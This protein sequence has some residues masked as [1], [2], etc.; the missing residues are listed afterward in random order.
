M[1]VYSLTSSQTGRTY[2]VT[3]DHGPGETPPENVFAEIGQQ[4]DEEAARAAGVDPQVL[5]QGPL[6]TIVNKVRDVGPGFVGGVMESGGALL[7]AAARGIGQLTGT[8]PGGLF[9]DISRAGEVIQQEG[10]NLRPTNPFNETAN[11]IGGG[12]QQA[13]GMV[14]T[15]GAAATLTGVKTAMTTVP[16][17]LGAVQGGGQGVQTAQ[18]MGITSPAGQLA[19]AVPFAGAEVLAERL[20]GVGSK[21]LSEAVQQ[22]M[23]GTFK[24]AAK[25]MGS[26]AIEEPLTG[27]LQD[28]TTAAAGQF[29]ADPQRPGYTTTG[30]ELPRLKQ[31]F[32]NRRVQEAIG[33]AAGGLVFAGLQ[34]ASPRNDNL[35]PNQT[36]GTPGLEEHTGELTAADVQDLEMGRQ[37]VQDSR[38]F[39]SRPNPAITGLA[40]Q[41]AAVAQGQQW[42]EMSPTLKQSLLTVR[43]GQ[44]D[45]QTVRQGDSER[46]RGVKAL[47]QTGGQRSDVAEVGTAGAVPSIATAYQS[48]TKGQSTAFIP[49]HD[50]WQQAK[51]ANPKLEPGDFVDE[52]M[53]QYQDG[54]VMLE[55]ANS[56]QEADAAGLTI[57][58]TPVGTAVRMAMPQRSFAKRT[59]G[60]HPSAEQIASTLQAAGYRNTALN[61]WEKPW[62]G[63]TL[64]LTDAKPANFIIA[65]GEIVPVDVIVEQVPQNS[66]SS[67][68]QAEPGTTAATAANLITEPELRRAVTLGTRIWDQV[69]GGL[70]KPVRFLPAQGHTD[71]GRFTPTDG[72]HDEIKLN[73]HAAGMDEDA[74]TVI[75]ELA[76]AQDSTGLQTMDSENPQPG[77]PMARLMAELNEN[78]PTAKKLNQAAAEWRALPNKTAEEQEVAE[79]LAYLA[80]PE[81]RFARAVEQVTRW[82]SQGRVLTGKGSYY[83]SGYLTVPEMQRILPLLHDILGHGTQSTRLS[84]AQNQPGG[85]QARSAARDRSSRP[86]PASGGSARN[87]GGRN[88]GLSGQPA[89]ALG[90]NETQSRFASPNAAKREISTRT[91]EQ[92]KAEAVA[93][94]D[95]VDQQMAIELFVN[96]Q[97]P[98]PLDA[99]EHAAAVLI[100]RLSEQATTGKTE[101]ARMWAHVQGQRMARV[102]T[103]EFLSAD[104]ARAMRQR[105]VVNNT[106]LAPIAPILA[107]Q[108]MLVDRAEERIKP[109]FD[110]GTEGATQKTRDVVKKAETQAGEELSQDLDA[111]T[112]MEGSAG[113]PARP[114]P[115]RRRVSALPSKHPNL[116]RMLDALRKKL[117]PGMTWADIFM[118]LPDTQ[119][120]RQREIYRRLKLDQRLAKLTSEERL[121]LTNELDKAWQRER[122]KVFL[123]ELEKA[124]VLGEETAKDREKVKAVAPK[125]LRLMNLGMMNSDLFREALAEQYGVK[126]ITA[127][128]GAEL[129]ALGERIQ[130]APEGL[131][132]RKLETQL[133]ERLQQLTDSTLFQ[134]LDSWWTASVLSG[135]RTQVD[136]GLSLLNG[137]EDVGLGGIVT[138]L[139]TGNKDVALR[140][141]GALFG[142]IPSAF[143]EAVDHVA[144]GNKA[145]MR[146]FEIE[147]KQALE[148]GNRLASDVGAEMWRKGG[149][150]K[151]PGAFMIFYGRLMTALDHINS[152]STMQ[153]AKMLALA[154]HPELYQRAIKITPADRAAALKQARFEMLG[155]DRAPTTQQE[156]IEVE[157]R[158]REL[159]DAGIPAEVL[160]ESREV[161]RRAALQGDPSGLGGVFIDAITS[162]VNVI[163]RK[164]QALAGRENADVISQRMARVAAAM[165]PL[166][167]ALTGTKFARTVAH[168][169]NRTTSYVPGIGLLTVGQ[170]GRTGVFGDILAAR[171]VVG[172]LVGIALYLAFDDDDDEKGIEDSWKDKTPQEKAQLYAQGKQPFTVWHRDAQGRVRS[173]NYQQWGIAGIMNTVAA[174]LKQRNSEQGFLNVLTSSLAQGMMSF[175]NKAQLQGLQT[176]FGENYRSTDPMTGIASNLNKWAAQT[177]GGIVPRLVKDIDLMASP[178]LRSSSEWWQKWAKEVPMLRQLSS[179]KR[180]DIFGEDI[181]LD[182]GPLSRVT[183]LG[184]ADPDYRLLARL[185]AKDLWLPDPTQGV[186]VVKLADGTR[187]NMTPAEKDRYQRLTGQAYRQFIRENGNTL[188][189]MQPDDAKD[190]IS[191]HTKYLRDTAAYQATH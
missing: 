4:L 110:G 174:M 118:D 180:V 114:D 185:N 127:Q 150:R 157:A 187:R 39:A 36:P 164:A 126:Q 112:G 145:L 165:V 136:I 102:W 6:G 178:E 72:T 43:E 128:T 190:W 137:I 70:K 5:D 17:A 35:P 50:V 60:P 92:V 87:D 173:Y 158:V 146:N 147:A 9:A 8:Q 27:T 184:T 78:L 67:A 25:T 3:I 162:A 171:Q 191:R 144:T 169:I 2:D 59:D 30:Y 56:Q 52:I 55:G 117:Y 188:L 58:G 88:E 18:E 81:E 44:G 119:K 130:Q 15:M 138:A 63:E 69:W 143:M 109:R 79:H 179:G 84:P 21:G 10:Q 68:R 19:M 98:L 45:N 16:L 1:P 115:K 131:P 134:I 73:R 20:G 37:G 24:Q 189:Q 142:R 85:S 106:I 132:R 177:A 83:E 94:L 28:A 29:V 183:M 129:R 101:V 104:P 42:G 38:S 64:R 152:A 41:A 182:R 160:N 151:V 140:G 135:W 76:H 99:A 111:E 161:G 26:E 91:D 75:H 57:Q 34:L 93:W 141:L 122:R 54:G 51:A 31:D 163:N 22:G 32:V 65:N 103:K 47:F 139:R 154:R 40:A 156:R 74:I 77:T 105:G 155:S 167:R 80:R 95:S 186:R 23:A 89:Q 33:G 153:G 121:A 168:A 116:K 100:S 12:V 96:Q 148:G 86:E 170:E 172:T 108:E 176:V 49:L 149:F 133:L 175:T 125:L 90:P 113:T 13:L 124:G 120:A 11:T 48:A 62:N 123:R 82:L 159:L 46:P 53:R 14:A 107:A 181:K 7:D 66:R 97:V 61:T 71:N 166:S